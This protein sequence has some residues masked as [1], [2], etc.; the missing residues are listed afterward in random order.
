MRIGILTPH[1]SFNYGAVLQAFALK[2]YIQS[3][4]H[5]AI[6]I[7]RR[8]ERLCAIPSKLGRLARFIEELA[9]QK[10]FGI[11]EKK[12]L[13]PQTNLIVKQS[14]WKLFPSFKLDAVI[15]GSDQVW[16]DDYVFNSFGF[17][18]FLDFTQGYNVK[19]IAYAPSLGKNSWNASKD[20]EEKVKKLL[21]KFDAISVREDTS[22]NILKD[23]FGVEAQLVLDPTMLLTSQDYIKK[24]GIE[25]KSN[26]TEFAASYILDYDDNYK[27]ILRNISNKLNIKIKG[28]N[29]K[30]P[31]NKIEEFIIRFSSMKPVTEW[32]SNIANAKYVITNSFHG[33]IFSI[34]FRKQFIVFMNS[35]RGA[36]R[37]K[38]LLKMFK[39][40]D[41]LIIDH[42][43]DYI[44][45]LITHIDYNL[46]NDLIKTNKQKSSDFIHNSL[47]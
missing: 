42:T 32:V 20:V 18:L 12:H 45:T 7:N 31:K 35:K 11:F 8:P 34:I 22:I 29:I 4:G 47:A 26:T 28:I 25:T 40:E 41:R 9:K 5:D 3:L 19:R 6:L 24:L 16:R 43:E 14:D 1:F 44:S 17:N 21:H 30:N 39:L 37:F 36:E 33:M 15:V 2:T 46:I 27:E 38:S 23:K 13:Q 10:S